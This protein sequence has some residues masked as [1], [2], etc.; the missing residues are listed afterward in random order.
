MDRNSGSLIIS[1]LKKNVEGQFTCLAESKI[2][3]QH[4][5][6]GDLLSL[7]DCYWYNQFFSVDSA[8]KNEKNTR[9]LVYIRPKI[10]SF[11]NSSYEQ[12]KVSYI[13]CRVSNLKVE[14]KRWLICNRQL[15]RR[16]E[17]QD[18]SWPFEK[19]DCLGHSKWV[20]KYA[21]SLFSMTA[22]GVC[23]T[24]ECLPIGDARIRLEERSEKDESVLLLTYLNTVSEL[25]NVNLL[26]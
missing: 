9:L 2:A 22:I 13:E 17:N 3:V 25:G 24:Y 10:R 20:R 7:Y 6:L 15:H 5:P 21:Y 16:Q 8:G 1:R 18:Q 11:M 23:N 19:M 4:L 14:A 26:V 12:N